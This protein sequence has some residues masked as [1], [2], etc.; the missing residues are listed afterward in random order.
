[1]PKSF[2]SIF[3]GI[4][5]IILLLLYAG[6]IS[7]IIYVVSTNQVSG[8]QSAIITEG[9]STVVSL[10]GGLISALVIAELATTNPTAPKNENNV[11]QVSRAIA[12][13]E[14]NAEIT[15][16]VK[17]VTLIYLLVWVIAGF[18]AFVAGVMIFPENS[19][20][21]REVGASWFGLAIAATYSYFGLKPPQ[22]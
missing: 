3:G 14:T 8:N 9:M 5:A 7:Y 18:S 17:N 16:T 2:A 13:V 1:M 19:S 22:Q 4:I 20:T 12:D 11:G 10:V 6:T 15:T 21:L